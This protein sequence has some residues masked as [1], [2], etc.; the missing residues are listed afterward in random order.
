ME[1]QFNDKKLYMIIYR[2]S[3][4]LSIILK[5]VFSEFIVRTRV[6]VVSHKRHRPQIGRQD[7]SANQKPG[8]F[9]GKPLEFIS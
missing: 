6:Q 8:F 4:L 5:P 3:A 1:K 2:R 9:G 7:R